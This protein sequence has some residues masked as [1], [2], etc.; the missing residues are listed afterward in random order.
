MNGTFA[1]GNAA[2]AE[3]VADL[4]GNSLAGLEPLFEAAEVAK[5]LKLDV[6]TVRRLFLDRADVVKLGR[7]SARGSRR[8]YVV[9]RIPLGAIQSFLRERMK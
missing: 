2:G 5:Y 8:S 9:L 6:T 1:R 7:T 3:S 4:Q